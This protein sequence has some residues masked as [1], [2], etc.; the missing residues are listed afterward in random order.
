LQRPSQRPIPIFRT[1]DSGLDLSAHA[2]T[3]ALI[4]RIAAAIA[5]DMMSGALH[6]RENLRLVQD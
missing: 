1:I 5:G 6:V 3:T 2:T 4:N